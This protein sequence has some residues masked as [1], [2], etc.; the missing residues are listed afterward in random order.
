MSRLA[1]ALRLR[2][3]SP[4]RPPSTTASFG[5]LGMATRLLGEMKHG[6]TAGVALGGAVVA[7]NDRAQR[8]Y[9]VFRR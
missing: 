9:K 3:V 1:A 4:A 7:F 5:M 6:L 8:C 2:A